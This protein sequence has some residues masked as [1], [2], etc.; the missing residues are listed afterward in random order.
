MLD[1]VGTLD[2]ALL[3]VFGVSALARARRPGERSLVDAAW[4]FLVAGAAFTARQVAVV[5]RGDVASWA[6]LA[7][8]VLVTLWPLVL[9]VAVRQFRRV[10]IAVLVVVAA[11]MGASVWLLAPHAL[12]A[13]FFRGLPI[14]VGLAAAFYL[15]AATA[16]AGVAFLDGWRRGAGVPRRRMGSALAGVVVVVVAVAAAYALSFVDQPDLVA[17]PHLIVLAAALLFYVA[18]TPPDWL[19]ALWR[20]K[21]AQIFLRRLSEGPEDGRGGWACSCLLEAAERILDGSCN[22]IVRPDG[23]VL[24]AVKDP[25]RRAAL[26]RL[27]G[28][29]DGVRIV[30]RGGDPHLLT[31]LGVPTVGLVPIRSRLRNHGVLAVPLAGR[32]LFL[33]NALHDLEDLAQ[34]VAAVLD[35][36]A[37]LAE[38]RARIEQQRRAERRAFE[39]EKAALEEAARAKG[40]F[41]ANMSHEL[42]TPLNA[43]IG[44]AGLLHDGAIEDPAT[45]REYAGDI[46]SAG[47]HLQQVIEDVLDLAK[48]DA[49]RLAISPEEVDMDALVGDVVGLMQPALEEREHRLRVYVEPAV[50]RVRVD[51]TRLRQVLF[52]YLSNAVKFTPAGGNLAVRVAAA[53]PGTLRVEVED[54]DPGIE[55]EDQ[56]RLFEEFEQLDAGTGK[57]HGGVGLG[58]ALVKRLVEAQGGRA[59]VESRPGRGSLFFVEVPSWQQQE[60]P[61][62]APGPGRR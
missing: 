52:N 46:L 7:Y 27:G 31:G 35:S 17:V 18:F 26:R 12:D 60:V 44:F 37:A 19:L 15:A 62:A 58:L 40:A 36:E 8:L 49:G 2:A 9:L 59:G 29:A 33:W 6:G 47:R 39:R 48:I 24:G 42:R 4:L 41:L 38:R 53:A 54:D 50:S 55:P 34:Q 1:P 43:V 51:P 22:A 13:R 23:R 45:I 20:A 56:A 14:G 28:R 10:P 3:L 21:E 32:P 16:V 5:A 11:A 57:Q 61:V 25:A 30:E